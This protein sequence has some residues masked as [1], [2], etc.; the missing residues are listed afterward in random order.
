MA[1]VLVGSKGM[2]CLSGGDVD[3]ERRATQSQG[4]LRQQAEP[5]RTTV[6]VERMRQSRRLLLQVY[7]RL[8][9]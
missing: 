3:V 7:A 4:L 8:Y 6:D 9:D 1:V 5:W 2:G